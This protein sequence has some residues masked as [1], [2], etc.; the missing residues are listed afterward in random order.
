MNSVV[1]YSH[2]RLILSPTTR[3]VFWTTKSVANNKICLPDNKACRRR[4]NLLLA[5]ILV[6]LDGP[7]Y[8]IISKFCQRFDM[9]FISKNLGYL[10][11]LCISDRRHMI[12]TFPEWPIKV[13]ESH[14][15]HYKLF[16]SFL[17]IYKK[18]VIWLYLNL[19][20]LRLCY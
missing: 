12:F 10:T 7:R 9:L 13:M 15:F 16:F 19:K 4:Q 2:K 20:W 5:T 1:H 3:F 17:Q 11:S 8:Y 14:I 18:N 6:V